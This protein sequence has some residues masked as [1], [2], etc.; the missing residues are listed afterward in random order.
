MA[1]YQIKIDKLKNRELTLRKYIEK[2][3]SNFK[4]AR[5]AWVGLSIF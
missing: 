5:K 1:N 4:F 2:I 3:Y